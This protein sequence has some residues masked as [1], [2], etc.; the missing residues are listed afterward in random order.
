MK[1]ILSRIDRIL[2]L[3]GMAVGLIAIFLSVRFQLNREYLGVALIL[4][5]GLYAAFSHLNNKMQSSGRRSSNIFIAGSII[6]FQLVL[7]LSE[8]V[9][10][11]LL[12]FR[13]IGYIALVIGATSIC[14]LQVELFVGKANLHWIETVILMEICLLSIS[15]KSSAYFMYPA[16]SGN[17]PFL[18][19]R[20]VQEIISNGVIPVSSYK[21]LPLTHL[22]SAASS[23]ITN[24]PPKDGLF[25]ISILQSLVALGVYFLG[26]SLSNVKTGLFAALFF[27][28]SDYSIQW[29]VQIIPMTFGIVLFT[30]IL[31]GIFQRAF[32]QQNQD[33]TSWTILIIILCASLVVTHSLASM[34]ALVM[35]TV[36]AV[37]NSFYLH[38]SNGRGWVDWSLT[39]LM[40]IGLFTYWMYA[41]P[42]PGLDFFSMM[43]KSVKLALTTTEVGDVSSVSLAQ[44]FNYTS[45]LLSEMGWSILLVFTI[46]GGIEAFTNRIRQPAGIF[47][48]LLAGL[49][50]AVTY[51]GAIVGAAAILP[52]RWIIFLYIP[53]SVLAAYFLAKIIVSEQRVLKVPGLGIVIVI[54]FFMITQPS[55]A[56]PDS[57]IYSA[58]FGYRPSYYTSEITGMDFVNQHFDPACQVSASA[59]TSLYLY[60]A[61]LLDP[62][63]PSTY[64]NA[65]LIVLRQFD[66]EKG[67]FI[68]YEPKMVSLYTPITPDLMNYLAS[69]QIYRTY[70]DG[71]TR[72]YA[73]RDCTSK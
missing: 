17:D 62:R 60:Q 14:A 22:I 49:F 21:F 67:I 35:L 55:R 3:L 29:G 59:K 45:L 40:C 72:I 46:A 71:S 8:V 41:F 4:G 5:S 73:T 50:L 32:T 53:A 65:G 15:I 44:Q 52:A 10:R 16:V 36:L 24:L 37:G 25:S 13:S 27:S 58:E 1:T 7:I 64:Q 68:P 31:I 51:G 11:N 33:K 23:I 66:F 18:H 42:N 19:V 26:R 34:I 28:L 56:M 70:D 47:V 57:P 9:V 43:I 38:R 30:L 2:V 20:I 61:S 48:T 6:S 39:I 63:K 69:Y 54:C 12:Y